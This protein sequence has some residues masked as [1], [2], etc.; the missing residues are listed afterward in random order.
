MQEANIGVRR[1]VRRHRRGKIQRKNAKCGQ[2]VLEYAILIGIIAMV[3]TA[4]MVYGKR[5]LQ[6]VI[7][8]SADQIGSQADSQP[9]M[10][11]TIAGS[12]SL[13]T[14]ATSDES[15][16]IQAG[17]SRTYQFDSVSSTTGNTVSVSNMY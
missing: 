15:N 12:A 8:G 17:E 13:S 7:K 5:G 14:T 9:S 11:S 1:Q 6:A 3:L 4:M 16:V 10:T 2:Q